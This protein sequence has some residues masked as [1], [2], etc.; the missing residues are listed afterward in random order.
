MDQDLSEESSDEE[1]RKLEESFYSSI[2]GDQ[3]L[4]TSVESVSAQLNSTPSTVKNK[5]GRKSRSIT[6]SLSISG[7]HS[8]NLRSRRSA[9]GDPNPI[10][11]EESPDSFA[12]AI[13]KMQNI[14]RVID[15]PGHGRIGGHYFHTW[16]PSEKQKRATTLTPRPVNRIRSATKTCLKIMGIYWLWS[17]GSS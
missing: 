3:G 2:T 17:G 6:P 14:T 8:Y 13:K 5:R 1:G 4:P 12:K 7:H 11:E 10:L 16:C 9:Q 15:P